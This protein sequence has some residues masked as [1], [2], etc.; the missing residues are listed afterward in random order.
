MGLTEIISLAGYAIEA[1]GV[2]MVMVG[3]VL[4]TFIFLRGYRRQ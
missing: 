2:L 1:T 3:S 4:S